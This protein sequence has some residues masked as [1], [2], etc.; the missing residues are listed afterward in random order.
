MSSS[1]TAP[2]GAETHAQNPSIP[3][4]QVVLHFV[5]GQRGDADL[6][7]NGIVV[8]PGGPAFP[9]GSVPPSRIAVNAARA[10][11]VTTLCRDLLGRD[12]EPSGLSSWVKRLAAGVPA[13]KVAA[14]IWSSPEHRYLE[15][16]HAAPHIRLHTAEVDAFRAWRQAWNRLSQ[17]RG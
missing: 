10:A 8:D 15:Q 11:F 9:T 1:T 14:A 6:I 13:Q 3:L 17:R 7:P 4:G 12:P 16:I 5:D 2:P